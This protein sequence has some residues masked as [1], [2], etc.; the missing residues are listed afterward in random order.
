MATGYRHLL[1][2][3]PDLFE[4][5]L[6]EISLLHLDPSLDTKLLQAGTGGDL[7][8]SSAYKQLVLNAGTPGLTVSLT[9]RDTA[10]STTETLNNCCASPSPRPSQ[11][12]ISNP[13]SIFLFLTLPDEL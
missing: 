3:L 6:P 4:L 13:I 8:M 5:P 12:P 7:H 9:Y 11:V 10:P 1:E 2:K